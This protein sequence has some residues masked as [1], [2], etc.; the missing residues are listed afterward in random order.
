MDLVR[1]F[2]RAAIAASL[3]VLSAAGT[4]S[5]STLEVGGVTQNKS[6]AF[7][8]SLAPSTSMRL[9]DKNGTTNDTCTA[10]EFKGATEGVFSGSKVGGKLAS[11]SIT[12]CS[13]TSHVIAPGS[14]SF[15][16]TSGTNASVS[17]SGAEWTLK[18]TV[19]GI[20]A[21]CKTGAGTTIGTLTGVKEGFAT[22]DV[23]ATTL[24]CGAL[25]TS[26]L[27]GSYIVTTPT[28]LGMEA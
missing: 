15:T 24:D 6:V 23:D 4:A 19:F 11:L 17:S 28:G 8:A 14:I 22:I 3:L 18:S 5:A 26:R 10:S 1:T 2:R 16:W 9:T 20:S 7:T 25:G 13:H 21:V 27:V 12:G